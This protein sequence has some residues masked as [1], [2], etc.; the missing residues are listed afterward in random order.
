[1]APGNDTGTLGVIVGLAHHIADLLVGLG[2]DLVDQLAGKVAGGIELVGHLL[3]TR[4]H[5]FEHFGAIE[6]LA[7]DDKPKFHILNHRKF[8]LSIDLEGQITGFQRRRARWRAPSRSD[9]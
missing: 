3:R 8:L 2:S 9:P 7:A 5:G 1:M 4:C 6:E